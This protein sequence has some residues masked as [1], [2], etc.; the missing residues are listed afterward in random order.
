MHPIRLPASVVLALSCP[1]LAGG[2]VMNEYNAVGSTKWL[3]GGSATVDATGSTTEDHTFGRI[4]GNRNNWIEFVVTQDHLDI[5]GWKLRWAETAKFTST[6]SDLWYGDGFVNQGVITFSNDT[7]WADGRF[8]QLLVAARA[9]FD[10]DLRSELYAEMQLILRD[11]GSA[12]IPAFANWIGATSDRVARPASIGNLW[13][14]DN[15][16]MAERWWIA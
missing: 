3:N 11:Q 13:P 10:P 15:A 9:E 4:L 14:M 16:R 8:E 1:A 6:G 12:I 2:L 5:R 7:R